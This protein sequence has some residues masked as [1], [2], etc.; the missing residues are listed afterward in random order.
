MAMISSRIY[1][2]FLNI[3]KSP[4]LNAVDPLKLAQIHKK[5]NHYTKIYLKCARKVYN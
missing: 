2:P 3:N 5:V 4:Y 1:Q